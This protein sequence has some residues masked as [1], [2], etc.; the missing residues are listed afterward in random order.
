MIYSNTESIRKVLTGIFIYAILSTLVVFSIEGI[1]VG[2]WYTGHLLGMATVILHLASSYI[3]GRKEGKQFLKAYFWSLISRFFAVCFIYAMIIIWTEIEE[4]S[5][6]FSFVISYLF[7]SVIEVIFL[8][9][10]LLD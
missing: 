2:S 6:T 9:N 10:K 5:F 8:N 3:F 7:H 1:S 4:I